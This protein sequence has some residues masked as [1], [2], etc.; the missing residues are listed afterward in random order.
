MKSFYII[1]CAFAVMLIA[2]GGNYYYIEDFATDAVHVCEEI[3]SISRAR[4]LKEIEDLQQT[5]DKNKKF[6][7]ITVNHTEIEMINN[8]LD[9]L[10]AYTR[11]GSD[12]DFEKAR[13]AAV[14]A[15]EELLLSEQ[16]SPTNIL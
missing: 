14:N 7:Q 12:A 11:H 13:R 3:Q 15:F 1:I 6:I 2:M 9:E 5:W 4:A 16:L 8:A 10:F